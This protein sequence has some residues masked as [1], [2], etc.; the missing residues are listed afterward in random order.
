MQLTGNGYSRK[1]MRVKKLYNLYLNY[2]H[3]LNLISW[4][5]HHANSHKQTYKYASTR[6]YPFKYLRIYKI[7]HSYKHYLRPYVHKSYI[8]VRV[9]AG[10]LTVFMYMGACKYLCM[11]MYTCVCV[12]EYICMRM[13]LFMCMGVSVYASVIMYMCLCKCAC[14]SMRVYIC[15]YGCVCVCVWV[16]LP[17]W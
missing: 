6:T 2:L 17:V 8:F 15:V 1:D 14:V 7:A 4:H 13:H 16:S 11:D 9:C 5:S 12:Y 3:L 10:Y